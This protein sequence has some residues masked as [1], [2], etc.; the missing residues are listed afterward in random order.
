MRT[1]KYKVTG[2]RQPNF[3]AEGSVRELMTW[4]AGFPPTKDVPPRSVMNGVFKKGFWDGGFN[5][6]THWEPFELTLDE[7][8][9]LVAEMLSDKAAD[10]QVLEAPEWIQKE[11]DWTAYV[12]W[13]HLNMPLEEYRRMLYKFHDL[14][15]TRKEALAKG[16]EKLAFTL[17]IRLGE[18]ANKMFNFLAKYNR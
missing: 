5:G 16:D 11:L 8:G 2:T 3:S 4:L 14:I 1:V 6:D 17:N 7:Y 12:N 13:H 18:A 10:Y 15:D 9:E